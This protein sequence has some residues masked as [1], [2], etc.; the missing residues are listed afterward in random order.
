[1]PTTE[2]NKYAMSQDFWMNAPKDEGARALHFGILLQRHA[3]SEGKTGQAVIDVLEIWVSE[4][5]GFSGDQALRGELEAFIQQKYDELQGDGEQRGRGRDLLD[6]VG[7]RYPEHDGGDA[8]T[9]R[10]LDLLDDIIEPSSLPLAWKPYEKGIRVVTK[11]LPELPGYPM[12]PAVPRDVVKHWLASSGLRQN[13]TDELFHKKFNFLTEAEN[14]ERLQS[15]I[16]SFSKNFRPHDV[17][18]LSADEDDPDV[19]SLHTCDSLTGW[20]LL[21]VHGP[22]SVSPDANLPYT[23]YRGKLSRH[24]PSNVYPIA[25]CLNWMR[26]SKS[27][28]AELAG[29]AVLLRSLA[30]Y[31]TEFEELKPRINWALNALD[32][33][34]AAKTADPCHSSSPSL[35]DRCKHYEG[36]DKDE[37]RESAR[38][39][40][41]PTND[42]H[43]ITEHVK[44]RMDRR[45][46]GVFFSLGLEN[47]LQGEGGFARSPQRQAEYE[48]LHAEMLAESRE[49]S[50]S[51]EEFKFYL[52]HEGVFFPY[53]IA[54]RMKYMTHESDWGVPELYAWARDEYK[55][56]IIK[57]NEAAEKLGLGEPDLDKRENW[58]R[59]AFPVSVELMNNV[60]R[61]K[62]RVKQARR[63]RAEKKEATYE[64]VG[65]LDPGF[66]EEVAW[67][68]GDNMGV[69]ISPIFNS[70]LRG[71]HEKLFDPRDAMLSGYPEGEPLVP[72]FSHDSDFHL[73]RSLRM[74]LRTV[75][76]SANLTNM[77]RGQEHSSLWGPSLA[78][79]MSIPPD[80]ALSALDPELGKRPWAAADPDDPQFRGEP[81]PSTFTIDFPPLPVSDVVDQPFDADGNPQVVLLSCPDTQCHP[82]HEDIP[83]GELLNHFLRAHSRLEHQCGD[84]DLTF[85]TPEAL[86]A[87]EHFCLKRQ[88]PGAYEHY[89]QLGH[90]VDSGVDCDHAPGKARYYTDY[91][92]REH[93]KICGVS[94]EERL[95]G[96][97]F[98]IC[99][100]M[101]SHRQAHIREHQ[102][103][104]VH[105]KQMEFDRK[106]GSAAENQDIC[107][108]C[109]TLLGAT[110]YTNQNHKENCGLRK[111][112]RADLDAFKQRYACEIVLDGAVQDKTQV[113]ELTVF[114]QLVLGKKEAGDGCAA[115]SLIKI[116]AAHP[117]PSSLPKS[118]Q[119]GRFCGTCLSTRDHSLV[120]HR[121]T[122]KHQAAKKL[123]LY[124][125]DAGAEDPDPNDK[126][127]WR[128]LCDRLRR[129]YHG[130]DPALVSKV[131][132]RMC[133][134]SIPPAIS[135]EGFRIL[136]LKHLAQRFPARPKWKHMTVLDR[137]EALDPATEFGACDCVDCCVVGLFES[138]NKAASSPHRSVFGHLKNA[139]F[140]DGMIEFMGLDPEDKDDRVRALLKI[141]EMCPG[142]DSKKRQASASPQKKPSS[143]KRGKKGSKKS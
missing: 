88:L 67:H 45:R 52:T 31:D 41:R 124:F 74:E 40:A 17:A 12:F 126:D 103:S 97:F 143:R 19:P 35:D 77:I 91:H 69:P 27:Y 39:R 66:M 5:P 86:N 4:L 111:E 44:E 139:G 81:P 11:Q 57:C 119:K 54:Y 76:F 137:I 131:V 115:T 130:K 141:Q 110:K 117:P 90:H 20:P 75:G 114:K 51:D 78:L 123:L 43:R 15:L 138:P 25:Q 116:I 53:H 59:V 104:A 7:A 107:P 70:I 84:C 71:G 14:Y 28:N 72:P 46:P 95:T 93:T 42:N 83:I 73:R 56:G 16:R 85:F 62:E 32:N 33:I 9:G 106:G 60:E 36:Q 50:W 94:G 26:D 34:A 37:L 101:H 98:C 65:D 112:M 125:K 30:D 23:F 128:E 48:E 79:F 132:R 38:F 10:P 21:G 89:Q 122:P 134:V 22:Y 1:M 3:R 64:H 129:A 68:V 13:L 99:G 61:V 87:H 140:L 142:S 92:L 102:N 108:E 96:Q 105:K 58:P 127:E 109:G 8:A 29:G 136:A 121:K 118:G 133:F 80:A 2:T 49:R 47:W 82:D 120:E 18:D 24:T 6:G 55:H 135:P 100:L 63:R 113:E